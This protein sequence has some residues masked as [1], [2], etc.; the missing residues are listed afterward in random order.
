M[1][2]TTIYLDDLQRERLSKLPRGVSFSK[3]VRDNFDY[4]LFP[5]ENENKIFVKAVG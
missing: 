5:Y 4:M 3:I 1:T 2:Q